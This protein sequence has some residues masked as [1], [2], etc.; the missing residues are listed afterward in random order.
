MQTPEAYEFGRRKTARNSQEGILRRGLLIPKGGV[1]T[2][3]R[4][5]AQACQVSL[6]DCQACI[7]RT[8]QCC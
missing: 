1:V 4:I 6:W 3:D 8:I 2:E 7:K 5:M